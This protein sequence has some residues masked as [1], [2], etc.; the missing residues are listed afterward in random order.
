MAC[1]A[2]RL[3]ALILETL[4]TAIVP[5]RTSI[6]AGQALSGPVASVGYGVCLLLLPAAWTDAPLTLQGS[7]D[8]GEPAAWADLYD[9]LGNEVV[10][11][12]TA[13]RALTLPPTL[14]LGWRWLRMRSGLAAAPVNQVAE[15]LLTLGI[16]PLA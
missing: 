6:A 2:Q 13:G 11:A 12:A 10:L 5:V 14:L 16:R 15:R 8:E 4:M 9:H 7:L 3:V 1:A